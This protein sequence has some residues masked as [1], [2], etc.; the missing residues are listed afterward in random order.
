[1]GKVSWDQ[2][3]EGLGCHG[4]YVETMNDL[5]P[6]LQRAKS[7]PGPALVCVR[8]DREAHT[9]IPRAIASRFMEVYTGPTP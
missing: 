5:A 3:A 6:A 2:V 4:E 1:M 7:A 9:N 8:T